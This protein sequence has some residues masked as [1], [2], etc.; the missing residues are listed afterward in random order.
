M[1][2]AHSTNAAAQPAAVSEQ[3]HLERA[4]FSVQAHE[5][6]EA[7][8]RRAVRLTA[9]APTRAADA[10]VATVGLWALLAAI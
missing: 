5:V 9:P 3:P 8:M 2:G 10:V 6:D 7:L 4:T 1:P